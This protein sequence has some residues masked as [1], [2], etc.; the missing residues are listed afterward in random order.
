[1]LPG[2]CGP[3]DHRLGTAGIMAKDRA[4]R[5]TPV[6]AAGDRHVEKLLM[7]PKKGSRTEAAEKGIRRCDSGGRNDRDR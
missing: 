7:T 2:I 4:Y 5:F 6:A 1:M 3:I